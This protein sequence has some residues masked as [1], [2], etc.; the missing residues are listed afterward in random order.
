MTQIETFTD[1][2]RQLAIRH[3]DIRHDPATEDGGGEIGGRRFSYWSAANVIS[4]MRAQLGFP[5]L[6]L[7]LYETEL[8]ASNMANIKQLPKAAITVL[9]HAEGSGMKPEESAYTVAETIMI[10]IIQQIYQ[11]HHGPDAGPCSKPFA[12]IEFD[13]APIMP[14]GKVLTN[15]YGWRFEFSFEFA[16]TF[17]LTKPPIAGTFI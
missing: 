10:S 2:F 14:T 12:R 16:R 7:E 4:G 17:D 1:Y 5:A 9:A 8:D 13:K 6:M 3:K 11:D 15:E